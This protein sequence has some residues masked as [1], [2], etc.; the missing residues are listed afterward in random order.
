MRK[1]HMWADI[2]IRLSAHSEKFLMNR[3]G[4]SI[5]SENISDLLLVWN[6]FSIPLLQKR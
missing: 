6:V 1:C 3:N 4:N 2:Y 5:L